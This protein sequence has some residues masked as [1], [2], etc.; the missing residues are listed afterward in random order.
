MFTA[1]SVRQATKARRISDL[2]ALTD[3]HRELWRELQERPELRRITQ[4]DVD[5]V[6][7]QITS[8][9]DQFLNLAIVHFNTGWL[10]T[11]EGAL[12]TQEALIKDV[13]FFFNLPIPRS[14]WERTRGN[15]DPEFAGFIESCLR[16]KRSGS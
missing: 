16:R 7:E 9:E 4:K 5:L 10:L 12:L 1:E 8:A 15:R 14:V 6:A 13:Q 2:L 11:R 3:Q